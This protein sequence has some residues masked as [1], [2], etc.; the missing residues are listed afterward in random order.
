[1]QK[2]TTSLLINN[3]L[4]ND[5]TQVANEFNNYFSNIAKNL[6]AKIHSQ[7][8]DFNKYLGDKSKNTFFISPTDKT[9][10]IDIIN[11]HINMNKASGPNSFP[12]MIIDLIKEQLAEPLSDIINL[13]FEK[14]IYIDKLKI[15]RIVPIYKEKGDKLLC[16]N[17]RPISLLSNINKIYEKLM[18]KRLYSFFED[19]NLIFKNQFGFRKHHSTTHAL[20][21]LTEDIRQA[22]DSN[23][24]ACGI[25]VDL[26]KA[27]DT[28]DHNILLKKLEHYGIRGIANDWIRSYLTN[29]QQYVSISGH[30]SEITTTELGVPQGSV[31]GPLLFLIYINDLHNAIKFSTTRHFAD[32]TNLLIKNDSLKQLKK[33]ANYD[34]RQLCHWLIANKIS[35][36]CDKT[37]MIIFRHPNKKMNYNV[38]IRI[39]G[40]KLQP[41]SHV[42]YLGVLLDPHLNWSYHANT[43]S[44]KLTRATGMLSKIRHY[45]DEKTVRNI[46]FGIFSSIMTYGAQVWGQFPNKHICR[47]QK[48]QNKALKSN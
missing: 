27:F 28:V 36:N 12:S 17:Y 39:N 7:G 1:M 24:Y 41:S 45:V 9:E 13:S 16:K 44:A 35:L 30:D 23:K 26:Q 15:S 46:Y 37:E 43:L 11:K 22:I 8:Q 3:N 42:K 10:I 33:H 19:Q 34:L 20:T 25:F 48:I 29:R 4:I 40:R 38:K 14:G 2:N 18:H 47:I 6:Q 21:D 32:D 31:L 5:P